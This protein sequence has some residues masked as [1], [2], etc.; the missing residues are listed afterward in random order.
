MLT[1]RDP[2]R[3]ENPASYLLLCLLHLRELFLFIFFLGEDPP[4]TGS[5]ATLAAPQSGSQGGPHRDISRPTEP[6]CRHPWE[7]PE[8][9]GC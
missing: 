9:P 1:S 8:M 3:L 2:T 7:T 6:H 5:G 4:N